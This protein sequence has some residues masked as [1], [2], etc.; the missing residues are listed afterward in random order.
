MQTAIRTWTAPA[1]EWKPELTI[2]ADVS[3]NL[4]AVRPLILLALLAT[5]ATPRDRR[6]P[7]HGAGRRRDGV[8]CH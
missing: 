6:C 8:R 5:G 7:T 4:V 2:L 1:P 3:A